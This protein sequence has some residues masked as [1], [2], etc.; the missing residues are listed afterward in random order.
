MGVAG[1]MLAAALLNLLDESERFEF[2]NDL[3]RQVKQFGDI[4]ASLD[5]R[6]NNGIAG[7]HFSVSVNGIVEESLDAHAHHH[8]HDHEH[9]HHHEHRHDHKYHHHE[10]D[11]TTNPHSHSDLSSVLSK[12]D[13]FSYSDA[14]KADAKSVYDSLALAEAHAHDRPVDLVHFHEVGEIDA[15]VDIIT[16]CAL[17]HKLNTDKIVASPIELGGGFVKCAH[18]ILPV[19]APATAYLIDGIATT[20]GRFPSELTTPTGAA[21]IK[22]FAK[23]F[24]DKQSI[25]VKKIGYGLGTKEFP[26]LNAV[27][28][29]LGETEKQL[30]SPNDEICELSVNLDDMTGEEIGFAVERL[31]ENGALDVFTTPINMKK[32]RPGVI[33]SCLVT[34]DIADKIAALMLSH[35]SSLG[36]RRYDCPRYRMNRTINTVNTKYGDVAIKRADGF[37]ATKS[38]PE[39]NDLEKIAKEQ[40]IPIRNIMSECMIVSKP[41]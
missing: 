7:Y 4:D 23:S 19:P 10:H 6:V 18:G 29:V 33:L 35:T 38:K 39:Y 22:H 12:I 28:V 15:I 24:S 40:N 1:D 25:V 34:P 14:V 36:V 3:N 30:C 41:D 26:S 11:H 27:R 20:M 2:I 17:I 8:G 5:K 9:E 32:N 31:Y 16:V 21:L 13:S 37:G